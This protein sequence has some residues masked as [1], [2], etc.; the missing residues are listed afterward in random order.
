MQQLFQALGNSLKMICFRHGRAS[1]RP[2]TSFVL[3]RCR[4][5]SSRK[6]V[7][8]SGLILSIV[9]PW[10]GQTRMKCGMGRH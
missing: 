1:S 4:T 2:S 7:V 6:A 5:M 9:S 3:K 10:F 8:I